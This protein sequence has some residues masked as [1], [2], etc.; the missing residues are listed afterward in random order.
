MFSELTK[1]EVVE[2]AFKKIEE[3]ITSDPQTNMFAAEIIAE[4]KQQYEPQCLNLQLIPLRFP[5][6]TIQQS[7][8]VKS[9][10][11]QFDLDVKNLNYQP[12]SEEILI[13]RLREQENSTV[14]IIGKGRII[15]DKLEQHHCQRTHQSS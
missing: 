2:V 13:R 11:R 5:R 1:K 8:D 4:V 6:I 12:V 7:G 9:G 3:R 15:P 14:T 10:F